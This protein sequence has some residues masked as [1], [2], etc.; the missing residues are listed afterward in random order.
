MVYDYLHKG[1]IIYAK[2]DGLT[3]TS[4]GIRYN[5][6]DETIEIE[7]NGSWI[8]WR[9]NVGEHAWDAFTNTSWNYSTSVY[10]TFVYANDLLTISKSAST[11][12][13]INNASPITANDTL[14]FK[15]TVTNNNSSSCV[16]EV[17]NATTADIS[18]PISEKYNTT[19]IAANT[20]TTVEFQAQI[21]TTGYLGIYTN[22]LIGS[23]VIETAY[24]S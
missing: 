14:T 6:T 7:V 20:T 23:I 21:N 11:G 3:Q 19:Y 1:I 17:Q 10:P 12:G 16:F 18:A 22:G 4:T 2:S 5:E 15:A 8:V 9:S 13:A 24:T